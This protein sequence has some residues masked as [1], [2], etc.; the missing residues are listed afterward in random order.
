M[1]KEEKKLKHKI[2]LRNILIVLLLVVI[3]LLIL[4]SCYKPQP[5]MK[6][7]DL[8]DSVLVESDKKSIEGNIDIPVVT[9]VTVPSD[10][11]WLHLSNPETNKDFYL[12]YEIYDKEG[13]TLLWSS[14]YIDTGKRFSVNLGEIFD[15]G[16]NEAYINVRTFEKSTLTECNGL[17]TTINIT[18]TK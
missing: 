10:M 12:M 2:W 13:G 5:A 11:P 17:H 4:K 7:V 9:D 18:I 14:K 3:A 15:V 16:I 6:D 1:E 8:E